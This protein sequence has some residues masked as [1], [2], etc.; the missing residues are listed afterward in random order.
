MDLGLQ[1]KVA[2]ITGANNPQ[3]IGAATAFAFAKEGAKHNIPI[4]LKPGALFDRKKADKW[5]APN[6][7]IVEPG[8]EIEL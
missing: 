7:L 6:K 2:I 3:G 8:Q 5:D 1:G 4:H